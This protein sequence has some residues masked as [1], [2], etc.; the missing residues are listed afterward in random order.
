M[1]EP[2]DEEKQVGFGDFDF[3]LPDNLKEQLNKGWPGKFYEHVFTE[4]DE[5]KFAAMYDSQYGRPNFPVKILVSLE[6]MKHQFDLSDKELLERFHFDARYIKALGLNEVGQ[7]T[8][9]ERTLYD[10]RERLLDYIKETGH[11]PLAEVFDDLVANFIE[12]AD[13]DTDIQRMDSTMV[14]ANIKH[15]SRIQLMRKILDNLVK[16]LPE[17]KRNQIHKNIL[18]TLDD[19]SFRNYLNNFDKEEIRDS[20]LGKLN[21]LKLLFKNDSEVNNTKAYQQL[22]RVVKEQ[23]IETTNQL[24][25]KD[26]KDV[27]SSSM[28][29]PHDE[30]A[31]YR[32][33]GSKEQKGYSVNISET[34]NPDNPAQMITDVSLEANIYSD[35]NFLKSRLAEINNKTDLEKLIID[36]AY[37]G[38]E[39]IKTAQVNDTE[40]IPT[41]LTGQDPKYSTAEFKLKHKQG[42]IACPMGK[43]PIR[44]KYLKSS[45]TYAAWFEKSDCKN[46]SYRDKC[47]ISEQ[48]KNM[49]VR[50]K[51]QR[52]DRDCLRAKLA[53]DKYQILKR[54]RAAIEGT[55]SALKRSQSLDK[56]KVCGKLKVRCTTMFKALGH[57]IKQLVRILNGD[58]R[59]CLNTS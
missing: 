36:G 13:L 27:K 35:V 29:N 26:D 12:V 52:Y 7:L 17:H 44:D 49:T 21:S 1:F 11:D 30:D 40:L 10:F 47:P 2:F 55:F 8:L 14:K 6:I 19:D 15:L 33:K 42:I 4:I 59:T 54:Y 5:S 56:F 58:I 25:A 20:L 9:G 39:S 45:D 51:K 34:S 50:F 22:C 37:Y 24:K 31:T 38:L 57:N 23:S 48:K 3:N 32:K 43:T 16:E 28:Q 53:S 18:K 41:S 46:C